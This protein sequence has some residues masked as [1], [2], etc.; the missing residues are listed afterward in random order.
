MQRDSDY[1]VTA[2]SDELFPASI[3]HSNETVCTEA[4]EAIG[5]ERLCTPPLPAL[6]ASSTLSSFLSDMSRE[7]DTS[8][9]PFHFGP[10]TAATSGDTYKADCSSTRA[11]I[12]CHRCKRRAR[13]DARLLSCTSPSCKLKFCV[14][15]LERHHGLRL[16]GISEERKIRCP[17][18]RLICSCKTCI[19][20]KQ[21]STDVSKDTI[22]PHSAPT[23]FRVLSAPQSISGSQ[24]AQ[25]VLPR[26]VYE[27]LMSVVRQS[28]CGRE[29]TRAS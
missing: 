22:L 2:S 23:T 13:A 28:L 29:E 5:S 4:G 20:R 11:T 8:P 21:R 9:S 26:D 18:C 27:L 16:H 3:L 1:N 19:K 10:C 24:E 15:C 6:A 17:R 12:S 7:T 14:G 25:V